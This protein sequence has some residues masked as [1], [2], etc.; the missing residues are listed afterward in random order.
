[1]NKVDIYKKTNEN[2]LYA[3]IK[4]NL[5]PAD[6]LSKIEFE[7]PEIITP[8]SYNNFEELLLQKN[9]IKNLELVPIKNDEIHVFYNSINK[10]LL[11]NFLKEEFGNDDIILLRNQYQYWLPED[12]SQYIIWM[13]DEVGELDIIRFIKNCLCYF[14]LNLE[15][16][17]LFERPRNIKSYLVKGT[18]P[19][20][21]HIHFWKKTS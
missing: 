12:V 10:E 11:A 16:I 9:K 18:F 3:E 2:I 21:R 4:D 20:Y 6:I 19:I 8:V 15:D 13:K 17:I 14:R 7:K 5:T 1:M